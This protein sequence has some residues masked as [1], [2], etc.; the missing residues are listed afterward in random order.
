MVKTL[1]GYLIESMY[2]GCEEVGN[3]LNPFPEK[4]FIL[5]P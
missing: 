3:K 5:I 4:L 1:Q 2:L